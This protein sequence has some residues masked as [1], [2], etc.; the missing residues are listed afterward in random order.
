[1]LE[2]KESGSFF[3]SIGFIGKFLKTYW[4]GSIVVLLLVLVSTYFN[5]I[6]PTLIGNSI[7]EMV[8][9]VGQQKVVNIENDLKNGKGLT[10]DERDTVRD[11]DELTK[12]QKD[13]ILNAS[14]KELQDFYNEVQFRNE[15]FD[16]SDSNILAGKGFSKDQIKKINNTNV[17]N[18]AQKQQL[19]ITNQMNPLLI[20]EQFVKSD[21]A[22]TKEEKKS[23]EPNDIDNWTQ[24]ELKNYYNYANVRI[25]AIKIDSDRITENQGF[26]QEQIDYINNSNLTKEQKHDI[27][28]TSDAKLQDVY[29][30]RQ[31][32]PN[33]DQQYDTFL[34]VLRKLVLA[35][36]FLSV[37]AYLYQSLMAITA[38]KTTKDMR[39]GLFG[40]LEE[41]SIRFFDQ[42]N[43]GDVLSRFTNDIDNISNAMNQSLVQVVSQG[44]LLVGVLIVMFINDTSSATIG[45]FE[46][47]N[48]LTW[49][50][51]VFALVAILLAIIIIQR[52]RF[53]I[54][55]QQ[56]KLGALNG[57]ID[58]RISGQKVV[59]SYG[60]EDETVEEFLVFNE[61][62]RTTAFK[63]QF[64]SGI[65]M[66]L[67]QGI[68]LINLG[69]LVF[70][71]ANYVIAG[72]MS[73]G[74]LTAF[75][76]YSQRFFNPLAQIVAQ[77]NLLELAATGANRVKDVYDVKAEIVDTKGATDI[78]G[79]DNEVSLEGVDFG[80]FKN[81]PVLKDINIKVEKGQMIALVGPTGSGKTT[82]MNLMN[83]FY[84]I[85]AG[86]IKFDGKS[87]K[88]ITISSL[89]NNVGIV[90]QESILF[91]GTVR[92]NI[93]Y[94][95]KDASEEEVINAAKTANI[96]EFIM[97]L[98]NGYD[99]HVDNNTSQFSTGQKQLMSIAR[100][101]I[102]N[103]DLLI[104]DEATSNVDTV[105]EANIQK[106]MENVLKGRTSFVIAHRLK[107]ILNADEIIVLKDGKILEQGNH[108]K[109]LD[110]DGFYAELYKNQFVIE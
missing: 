65:L 85:D 52:A 74:L 67:I 51:I 55:K 26:S 22:L 87:I 40:K 18:D 21:S 105:T 58:E 96:H 92:E 60:L 1:M 28:H 98:D 10:K 35:Y 83:R 29:K 33:P 7:D 86:D 73:I 27:I 32:D 72:T 13:K 110:L 97:T 59:I 109:L 80:Y 4:L 31:I 106:A 66:P 3:R 76:Q 11:S 57:Y 101:I 25:A 103:P 48:V 78:S 47:N 62:L 90:L 84:D 91:D 20:E 53:H 19:L 56:D 88:D 95:K 77:Y 50:M 99:T 5:V 49:M 81:Q 14:D 15:L 2:N 38:A 44:A 79:I 45:N 30:A 54:S 82:V 17:L 23:L 24:K 6:S 39:I 100:T 43:D 71:G 104:L 70:A 36:I 75:I 93:A 42:S 46:I 108:Q 34:S 107:T 63:G 94:G 8:T 12:D 69:V 9:Y 64:Y 61:D 89:R 102:T 16:L 68:G 41:L 37:A